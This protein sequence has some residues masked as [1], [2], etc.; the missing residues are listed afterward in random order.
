MGKEEEKG[1]WERRAGQLRGKVRK[2]AGS[3]E[4]NEKKVA[5]TTACEKKVGKSSKGRGP[6]VRGDVN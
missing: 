5:G 1:Q 6:H 3:G 2:G 4:I